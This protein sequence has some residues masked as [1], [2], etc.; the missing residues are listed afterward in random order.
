MTVSCSSWFDTAGRGL[1][2]LLPAGSANM[3]I[4]SRLHLTTVSSVLHVFLPSPQDV[5]VAVGWVLLCGGVCSSGCAI[6]QFFPACISIWLLW[7]RCRSLPFLSTALLFLLLVSC[8][9]RRAAAF[10]A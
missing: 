3:D 6:L 4:P 2:Y 7:L 9:V 10:T 8:W 1:R 5:R